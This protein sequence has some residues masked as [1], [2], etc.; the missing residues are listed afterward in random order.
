[1]HRIE[2]N[3]LRPCFE[4]CA[5]T[6]SGIASHDSKRLIPLCEAC[7]NSFRGPAKEDLGRV[8]IGNKLLWDIVN[9]MGKLQGE[10]QS[11]EYQRN[12]RELFY[13]ASLFFRGHGK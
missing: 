4:C 6:G 13:R 11:L 5:K 9:H 1:M 8:K 12:H 3:D 2:D 7:Y 10:Y